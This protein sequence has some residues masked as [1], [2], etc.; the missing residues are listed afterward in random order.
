MS[1]IETLEALRVRDLMQ[2]EVVTIGPDATARELM[3]LLDYYEI[4]GVPVVDAEGRVLGVVSGRDLIRFAAERNEA[5]AWYLPEEPEPKLGGYFH[6]DRVSTTLLRRLEGIL[7]GILVRDIMTP[8][9]FSVREGATIPELARFLLQSGAHRALVLDD[10]QLRGI[11]TT[12]DILRAL[13]GE[14]ER[15]DAS[16]PEALQSP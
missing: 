16:P 13:A 9:V 14:V 2:T 5:P 11:V 7:E 12:T 1:G 6:P 8:A 3:E 10:G 4:G 15:R